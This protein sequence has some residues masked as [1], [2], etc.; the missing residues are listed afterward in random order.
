MEEMEKELRDCV[1]R[2]LESSAVLYQVELQ[3]AKMKDDAKRL[4]E[5][6]EYHKTRHR[7]ATKRA[8]ELHVA[9]ASQNVA[10]Q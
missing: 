3:V 7:E 9:I 5:R 2:L 6:L 1:D 8:V 4:Y 10:S